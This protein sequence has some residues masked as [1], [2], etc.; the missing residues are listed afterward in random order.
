VST[1]TVPSAKARIL[2]VAKDLFY[3]EGIRAVGIDRIIEQSGV[4]KM[5]LYRHFPSKDDLIVA[6]LEE[7]NRCHWDWLEGVLAAHPDDP[8]RQLLDV[9]DALVA[10]LSVP[11]YRG[12]G[13]SNVVTEFPD[14][15]H[16]GRRVALGHTEAMRERLTELAQRAGAPDAEQLGD[17]LVLLL[18]GAYVMGQKLDGRLAATR[19]R[20]MATVLIDTAIPRA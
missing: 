2:Q 15:A 14:A 16:P 12:C 3:E 17:Q 7:L 1:P 6:Y 5:T 8:R 18:D 10:K 20:D 9:F 11:E 13:F 4:A 19:A